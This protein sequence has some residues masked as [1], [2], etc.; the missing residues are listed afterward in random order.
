MKAEFEKFKGIFIPAELLKDPSITPLQK[1]L[2]M[3]D[4]YA[5]TNGLTIT[6]REKA[7]ILGC[8][9]VA[10]KKIGQGIKNIPIGYKEYTKRKKEPKKEN[11]IEN[12]GIYSKEISKI[13]G[14]CGNRSQNPNFSLQGKCSNQPFGVFAQGGYF[15]NTNGEQTDWQGN[16][17][18]SRAELL[19]KYPHL[20]GVI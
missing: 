20:K 19:E 10:I 4:A 9:L 11:N 2:I 15:Y 16:K 8:S 18:M 17:I 5:K 14:D 1:L 3:L 12:L 13:K 7:D 6:Q